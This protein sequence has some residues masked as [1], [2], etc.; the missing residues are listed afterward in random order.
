MK[1]KANSTILDQWNLIVSIA[2]PLKKVDTIRGF[3]LDISKPNAEVFNASFLAGNSCKTLK[4]MFS[5][6]VLLLASVF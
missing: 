2:F 1:K 6:L 3:F 5:T 4:L